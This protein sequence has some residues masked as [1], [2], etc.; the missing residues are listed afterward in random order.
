M[1]DNSKEIMLGRATLPKRAVRA[2]ARVRRSRKKAPECTLD[3]SYGPRMDGLP[4]VYG[5]PVGEPLQ[6]F[7]AELSYEL[8]PAGETLTWVGGTFR[9]VA[10]AANSSEA[11]PEADS[12]DS[13]GPANRG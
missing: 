1:K 13:E 8:Q 9:P 12:M 2:K 10:P 5:S 11:T 4:F 7:L 6:P 3:Y